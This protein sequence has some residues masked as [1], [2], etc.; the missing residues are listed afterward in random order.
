MVICKEYVTKSSQ[1]FSLSTGKTCGIE[2]SS[3]AKQRED[4][5]TFLGAWL[6]HF[7]LVFPVVSQNGISV[8]LVALLIPN[9]FSDFFWPRL[10]DPRVKQFDWRPSD[11]FF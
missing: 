5:Q 1:K 9:C 2:G 11:C 3:E 8:D 7:L 10:T 4:P 6:P